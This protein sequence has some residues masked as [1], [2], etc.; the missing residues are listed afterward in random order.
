MKRYAVFAILLLFIV[1]GAAAVYAADRHS[2]SRLTINPSEMK[3]GETKTFT[4]DGRKVTVT[5]EGNTTKVLIE[6][7]DGTKTLSITNDDGEI[8]IDG[9]DGKRRKVIQIGPDRPRILIDGMDFKDFNFKGLEDFPRH[10][11][12]P[13]KAQTWFVCPKD[14]TM[15]R[16]PDEKSDDTFKCPIDGTTMEKKK[17]RGFAFFFDDELF[18]SHDM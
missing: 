5:R 7:A 12:M 17:G 15:L 8:R 13:R 9:A 6:G 10:G 18:E 2:S 11:L 1:A 14:H 4:D 16:V 3:D